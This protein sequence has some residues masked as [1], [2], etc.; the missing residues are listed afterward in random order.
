MNNSILVLKYLL[1]SFFI[2]LLTCYSFA[3]IAKGDELAPHKLDS[4]QQ[5]TLDAWL[6]QHSNLR[7]AE[8]GDCG[9]DMELQEMRNGDAMGVPMPEYNPYCVVGDFNGDGNADFSVALVDTAKKEHF[10]D[11]YFVLVVFNGPFNGKAKA[12]A[13]IE[14]NTNLSS[15]GLFFGPPSQKPYRLG[16]GLFRSEG[17]VLVPDKRTYKWLSGEED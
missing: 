17:L 5:K 15:Q 9:C 11:N 8:I 2:A 4:E 1:A 10:I 13:F 6:K 12:P 16:L 14:T 7:L 3:A